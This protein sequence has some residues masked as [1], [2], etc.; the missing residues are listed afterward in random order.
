MEPESPQLYSVIGQDEIGK[1]E[2][3][4]ISLKHKKILFLP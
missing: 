1:I 4:S 3:Q 2:I